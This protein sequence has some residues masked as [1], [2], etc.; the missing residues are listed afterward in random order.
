MSRLIFFV[1]VII[2]APPHAVFGRNFRLFCFIPELKQLG[3]EVRFRF[4]FGF[5][6]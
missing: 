2:H 4:F 1:S 6:R 5:Q 3:D